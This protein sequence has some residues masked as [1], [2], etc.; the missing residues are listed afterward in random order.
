M[1]GWV[2]LPLMDLI[3]DPNIINLLLLVTLTEREEN[4]NSNVSLSVAKEVEF[5]DGFV[6][7]DSAKKSPFFI[8]LRAIKTN[9]DN[10][11]A[12]MQ[13]LKREGHVHLLQ[14]NLSAGIII[15]NCFLTG[16]A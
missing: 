5:L 12:L 4:S 6:S 13:F 2:L 9:N 1:A 7:L 14:F 10:L 15:Y 11:Y 16:Y 8:D 3:A